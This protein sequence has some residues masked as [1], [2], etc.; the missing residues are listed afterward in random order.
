MKKMLKFDPSERIS[1]ADALKHDFFSDL[2]C[3]EDEPTTERVDAFDFDFEKYDLTIDELKIE[4]FDEIS[5]YHSAKAQQK[6]IKN[7]KDHPEGVLHLKHKRIA[8]Q[9][10][11]FKR[12]LPT[13]KSSKKVV[14]T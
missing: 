12:I 2:H 4:I 13:K 5:L 11:K 6:Y 3:E 8:D 10:K 14:K 7:R 9:C 1:V